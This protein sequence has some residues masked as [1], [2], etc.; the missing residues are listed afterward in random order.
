MFSGVQPCSLGE[1]NARDREKN[2]KSQL[3]NFFHAEQ[4]PVAKE[5]QL[6]LGKKQFCTAEIRSVTDLTCG[7]EIP[8]KKDNIRVVLVQHIQ[9]TKPQQLI[10]YAGSTD[11]SQ[12]KLSL[13]KTR[14]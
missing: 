1:R 10:P 14:H 7:I 5:V 12:T 11:F 9:R 6:F 2:Y 4:T 8:E 13:V 3:T